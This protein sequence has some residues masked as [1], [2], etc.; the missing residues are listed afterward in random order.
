MLLHREGVIG[1][2]LHRRVVRDDHA[3]VPADAADP[4]DR[5]GAGR[6]VVRRKL[7]RE[8]SVRSSSGRVNMTPAIDRRRSMQLAGAT[9]VIAA[10]G[11]APAAAPSAIVTASTAPKAT[12]RISNYS[13]LN[14]STNNQLFA[15]FTKATGVE[16][17]ALPLAAAG[18][19]QTKITA[20]KNKP[21]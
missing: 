13:A 20:E 8:V 18:D 21:Q 1:P 2:A 7:T 6:V 16:V 3:L 4:G 9:A 12:G 11:G 17:A 5:P 15:A 19:L 14:D 10:C